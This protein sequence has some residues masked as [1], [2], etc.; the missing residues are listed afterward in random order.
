METYEFFS[1]F[2]HFFDKFLG[3]I[4]LINRHSNN[5]LTSPLEYHHIIIFPIFG[6]IWQ[7]HRVLISGLINYQRS[8]DLI[9]INL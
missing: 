9:S 4:S 1:I 2:S 3:T 7:H 6:E 8:H 5:H